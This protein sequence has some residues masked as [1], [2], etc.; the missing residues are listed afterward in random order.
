M[1]K[2]GG[3]KSRDTLPLTKERVLNL[4]PGVDLF[5]N[6]TLT[7]DRALNLNTSHDFYLIL[8]LSGTGF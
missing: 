1:N 5:L 6:L 2:N 4:N 3:R 7:K 8:T